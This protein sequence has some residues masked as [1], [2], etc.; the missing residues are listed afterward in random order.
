MVVKD[1]FGIVWEYVAD[2][3]GS[4]TRPG[5]P[6][7]SDANEWKE[8]VNFPTKEFIDSWDW[9]EMKRR[10]KVQIREGDFREIIICTGYFERLISFMDF[11]EAAVAM[12]DE[13]QQDAIKELF[14][15]LS[16]LY[17]NLINKY[18]DVLGAGN[19]DA[20]CLHD[21][22]G[23]QRGI[24]FSAD[25]LREMVVPYMRRVTDYIHEKGMI[26]EC[27]SCGKV[28]SLLPLYVEAGFEMLE[29]Q[30]LLDFD[31][32][33]PAYGDK[34]LMHVSPDV[35]PLD[36]PEGEHI[37]AARQFVDKMISYGNPF[38]MDNYYSP[39]LLSRV[40][41]D[42]VYRYSRQQLAK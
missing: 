12:I 21:D 14:G 9:A 32:D 31:K 25:T 30:S 33:V 8:K 7:L 13:D 16:D 39:Y 18:L 4:T 6:L 20:V 19:V 35:P 40:F 36:A 26:A 15:C 1:M 2:I 24:F 41:C 28:D 34:L 10:T 27:H 5:N 37:Q 23:H 17:I 11:E 29:C 42:E 38:L 22:W 3:G